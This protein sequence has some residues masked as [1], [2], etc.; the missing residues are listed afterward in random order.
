MKDSR[1]YVVLSAIYLA[2]H[3]LPSAAIVTGVYFAAC[4]L[5]AMWKEA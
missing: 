1:L 4:A 5:Y 3:F 2:P